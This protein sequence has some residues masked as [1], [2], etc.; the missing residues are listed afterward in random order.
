[1]P[2]ENVVLN[3][4]LLLL[5]FSTSGSLL[6]TELSPKTNK[7]DVSP[8]NLS[9][10]QK[11]TTSQP[12]HTNLSHDFWNSWKYFNAVHLAILFHQ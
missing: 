10:S 2:C 8:R 9:Y 3:L 7:E 5:S 12:W 1:L 4:P 11:C 6:Y